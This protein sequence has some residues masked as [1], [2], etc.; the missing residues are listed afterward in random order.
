MANKIKFGLKNVHY[1]V[2]TETYDST[3]GWV[4]TYGTV[5]TWAGAVSITLD[6]QGDNTKFYADDGVYA[7]LGNNQG[8]EGDFE[9]ALVPEDVETA[10]L[11]RT[12]ESTDKVIYETADDTNTVTYFAL[13]FEFT[14][15][16]TGKRYVFYRCSLTRPS[17][18]S[19]TKSDSVDVQTESVTI[20]ATP[21]LG[22]GLVMSHTGDSTTDTI[23][24]GWYTTVYVPSVG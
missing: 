10:L 19:N 21:R 11:N 5:K 6:P 15:D 8:Y 18:A 4:T 16:D 13:M 12:L 17:V 23:Y 22:D 1:A 14:G 7:V 9:S 3:N 20:T 24:N 2:A